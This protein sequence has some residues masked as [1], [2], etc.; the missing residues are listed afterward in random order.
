MTMNANAK[1][2]PFNQEVL[3][4]NTY[5]IM[6]KANPTLVVNLPIACSTTLP[7]NNSSKR[8]RH[9]SKRQEHK[10]RAKK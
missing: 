5:K 9:T 4:Q 6:K 10:T 8:L 7:K 1:Q 3:M 2:Q